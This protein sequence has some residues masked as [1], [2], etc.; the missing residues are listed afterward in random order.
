MVAVAAALCAPAPVGGCCCCCWLLWGPGPRSREA[1]R[2][3]TPPSAS[4]DVEGAE[5][6]VLAPA[7]SSLLLM[8]AD[9]GG[10]VLGLH[11]ARMVM[12]MACE[13]PLPAK[14]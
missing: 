3:S 1:M 11:W 14:G 9:E 6:P 13:K 8:L 2:V 12:G 7:F 10:S 5:A 4:A